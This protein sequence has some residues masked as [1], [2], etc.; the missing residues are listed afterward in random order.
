MRRWIAIVACLCVA[1]GMGGCW[2]TSL[3]LPAWQTALVLGYFQANRMWCGIAGCPVELPEGMRVE[4]FDDQ[5]LE[6]AP[7]AL[8]VD[9]W[10]RVY[11][12]LGG[13]MA[14]GAEDNRFSSFWLE[15]DLASSRV[16][17]RRAYID[18]WVQAGAFDDPD[19]FTAHADQLVVVEDRDGDG[20]ADHLEELASFREPVDGLAAGIWVD[21]HDVYATVIPNLWHLRVDDAGVR[22]GEPEVLATG[23]GVKTSLL[24]HDL[25]GLAEGPDGK[26]YFSIGDRGYRVQLP[27]GRVLEPP[28]GPGR[29]AVFRIERDGSGLEVF[30]TGLRNPQELAFDDYGNLF[31]GENNGDGGDQARIVYVVEGGDSGWAMPYQTL[32]G[33]YRLGPWVDE[34]LWRPAHEG[35]AA[36]IVPPIANLGNGPAGL[37]HYPG[38]GLPERYRDH[39]FMADYGYAKV[40]SGIW[41]FAFEPQGAGFRLVD[42]HPFAWSL[43]ATDLAFG[44]GGQI[45]VSQFSQFDWL[46]SILVLSHDEERSDP[47]IA[48]ALELARS[49]MEGRGAEELTGLLAHPDRRIRMKA[50]LELVRR[51]DA[52]ALARVANDPTSGLLARL[53]AVW[54]LGQLGTRGLRVAGWND[55]AWTRSEPVEVR[56]QVAKVAG[57]AGADWLAPDLVALLTDE[58]ARVQFFA[59]QS[60]GALGSKAA[61]GPLF[62]L[63][64]RNDD[65]DVFLRHAVV[66]AL[67]R[68]GDL[69]SVIAHSDAAN[70]SVRLGALLVLRRAEDPRIGRFMSDPDPLLVLEAARAIYDV[71][72]P[73]A[74]PALARAQVDPDLGSAFTRRQ[75]GANLA[76]GTSESAGRLAGLVNDSSQPLAMREL[77]LEALASFTEPEPRDL[78]MGFYR[79]LPSRETAVVFEAFDEL[80]PTL[81]EGEL[82]G[83]A[84]EVAQ[85]YGRVPLS[86]SE[87]AERVENAGLP[88][89]LRVASLSVLSVREPRSEIQLDSALEVALASDEP[90]LRAQ[91]REILALHDPEA[92]LVALARL[93]AGATIG[94]RQRAWQTLAEL[95]DP[96]ADALVARGLAA[97]RTGELDPAE[98][99]EVMEAVVARDSPDMSVQLADW[100][101]SLDSLDPVASYGF[102]LAGGDPGR[103]QEIFQGAGDCQRCHTLSGHKA[104]AGPDLTGV[105]SRLGGEALLRAVV[106]PQADIAPGWGTVVVSTKDGRVWMGRLV[107]ERSNALELE[108]D[109]QRVE[110]PRQQAASLRSAAS[111]MPS[112]AASL[113]PRDLRDLIAYLETR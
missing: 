108:I 80:G 100:Q 68:I 85:S 104:G 5:L 38:L 59:A 99:L 9:A 21:G 44:W 91:A 62:A 63:L 11:L 92:A 31:T 107:E 45:F 103:G 61:V 69:Q 54:G 43:L 51:G 60:L 87:L 83:R 18:K 16:S 66:H 112:M 13:R 24:G 73:E 41:S 35:Q 93:P 32:V 58:S 48:E 95:D 39:F 109:G 22:V 49:G 113:E 15:D 88:A 25:H 20:V 65:D 55:L 97:L 2:Q 6:A 94:E 102:A 42:E 90:E 106:D 37:A 74:M 46:Q 96:G 64:E 23:F 47:R 36:W 111:P 7:V 1:V 30:A 67:A 33:D 34:D 27:D 28:L 29:G 19:H 84:L 70:R 17:H 14:G 89:P 40:R 10:G 77:A 53:H 71:P 105:G 110:I 72:I 76:L 8:D 86:N 26:L 79:P 52:E 12:A 78:A 56:S 81:V 57:T 75:I 82:G 98:Q 101:A 3:G 4:V 50:Q